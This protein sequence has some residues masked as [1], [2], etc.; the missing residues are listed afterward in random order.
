MPKKIEVKEEVKIEPKKII[1]FEDLE[2][3]PCANEIKAHRAFSAVYGKAKADSAEQRL[4][5]ELR[6]ERPDLKGEDLVIEIYKGLGGLLNV[7]QAKINRE[8][9]KRNRAARART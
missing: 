9:D 3:A 8:V 6:I 1:R 2:L 5:S 4:A 7:Q